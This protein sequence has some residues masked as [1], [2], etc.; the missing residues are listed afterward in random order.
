MSTSTATAQAI[1]DKKVSPENVFILNVKEG[2]YINSYNFISDSLESAIQ[3]GKKY[4][5]GTGLKRRFIH[6][7]PFITDFDRRVEEE[8]S[9]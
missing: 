2:N 7:R 6:V 5:E 9:A 1:M 4:C 8:K 3:K